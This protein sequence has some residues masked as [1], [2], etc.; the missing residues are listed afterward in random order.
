MNITQVYLT[1][2][3]ETKERLFVAKYQNQTTYIQLFIEECLRKNK[4][5][6]G[7]FNRLVFEEGGDE[8]DDFKIV[9]NNALP[10]SIEQTYHEL[11]SLLTSRGFHNY[12]VRKYLE[13][14][15]RFDSHFKTTFESYLSPLLDEKYNNELCYEKKM[16]TKRLKN[17]RLQAIGSYS[18]DTFKLILNVYE[19]NKLINSQT[20]FECEPDMFI[21]KYDLHKI[22]I[23]DSVVSVFNKVREKTLEI[24]VSEMI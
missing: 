20:V 9:G 3:D 10:V 19:K 13:G 6:I 17:Y 12:F 7:A 24:N 14:F 18:K 23:S 15:R 1:L 11:D 5:N 4:F 16:A 21:V 2:A 8:C 22:E